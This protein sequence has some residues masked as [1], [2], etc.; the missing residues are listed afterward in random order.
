LPANM[1][2][3]CWNSSGWPCCHYDDASPNG[4]SVGGVRVKIYWGEFGVFL[5]IN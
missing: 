4:S 5:D 1:R 2:I 3:C